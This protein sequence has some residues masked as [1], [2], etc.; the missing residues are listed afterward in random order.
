ME[1][2]PLLRYLNATRETLESQPA[3][4][5]VV[6]GNEACDLDSAVSALVYAFLLYSLRKDSTEVVLPVLNIPKRDYPLKT[7]VVFWLEKHN[8][9]PEMLF[10]RDEVDLQHQRETGE[11]QLTLVDHHQLAPSDSFL[12]ASVVFI[13]D[14]RKLERHPQSGGIVVEMVGSCCTLVTEQVLAR[15]PALLDSVTASLL[16]GTIILDTVNLNEAAK[17]VTPKDVDM[18][19]RLQPL[20]SS[21]INRSE[22]F[23]QLTNA[24]ANVSGL[25]SDQLLRKDVKVTSAGDLKVG[26]ASVP[27]MVKEY[28]QRP[29][30]GETLSEHCSSEDYSVLVIMGISITGEVVHRDIAIY[31][32]QDHL[33]NQLVVYLRDAQGEV[34]QLL[35]FDSDIVGCSAFLQRNIAASRKV[36]LPLI[37]EWLAKENF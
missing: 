8:I 28:L 26:V 13:L 1:M 22:I 6:L 21:S 31:S 3:R 14:H 5:H 23:Q 20:L 4:L 27:M 32:P 34:L 33:R 12:D 15:N 16:Y 9:L 37:K 25:T 24:K 36:V 2:F 7:E 19:G 35:P 18:I 11:L 29:E 17:R 10:F 30:V